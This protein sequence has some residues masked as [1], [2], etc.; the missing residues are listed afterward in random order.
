MP[1]T[2]DNSELQE[3]VR[4]FPQEPGVYLMKSATSAILYVGKA[5]NLRS[6]VRSYFR[7][8]DPK[9]RALMGKVVHIEWI[10][11]ASNYEALLLEINLIKQWK[12]PYNIDLRDDKS[13]ALIRVTKEEYPR[14]FI[15]RRIVEDGSHYY[16]PY[17]RVGQASRIMELIERYYPLRRCRGAIRRR[18]H[19]CLYWH[20]GQCASP[21]AG[22]T[23]KTEYHKRVAQIQAVL[24]GDTV[25]LEQ[26]L[27][28]HIEAQS[29][30]QRYEVALR[31]RDQLLA[32][33]A[34]REDEPPMDVGGG[35]RDYI[36]YARNA[37]RIIVVLFQSREGTLTGSYQF[38]SEQMGGIADQLAQFIV[39]FYDRRQQLPESIITLHQ[40]IGAELMEYYRKER[41]H[42]IWIGTPQRDRDHK[43][44]RLAQRNASA[45]LYSHY[46]TELEKD[47]LM[48]LVKSLNLSQRPE[49]IEGFDVAHLGGTHT[50]AAMVLFREGQPD[51]SAYRRFKLRTLQGAIDDFEALRETIARRYTRLKNEQLPLPDLIIIDGGIG[52][53]NAVYGILQSLSLQHIALVAIAKRQE[54]LYLPGRSTPI[55]FPYDSAALRLIQQVRDEAHR[56]ATNYRRHLQ[57]A[58]LDHNLLYEIRGVGKRRAE[59]L[60]KRYGSLEALAAT[61]W[62][63]LA[64]ETTLG[65][66]VA[67]AVI[68]HL[69][70]VSQ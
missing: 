6:R 13:Y 30:E 15:T 67:Q 31:T 36:G 60:L 62:Q 25:K 39:Q 20:I 69:R 50:V 61:D 29:V 27:E 4:T 47:T 56:F 68:Q 64:K 16:G 28:R 58:A 26:Q 18:N 17:V 32:L 9:T 45:E 5:T 42:A 53:V 55:Q 7:P 10:L 3:R 37:H 49:H 35:S 70:K 34:L 66:N 52:Q 23:D 14:V 43:L 63:K 65:A 46:G 57:M 2:V 54:Q 21:C 51:K 11:T 19:P 24:S 38:E 59:M 8:T 40:E 44:V 33:R 41:R 22:K 12:P 1:R 48:E